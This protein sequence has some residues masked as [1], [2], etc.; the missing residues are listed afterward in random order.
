MEWCN[1]LLVGFTLLTAILI[2]WQI[3]SLIKIEQIKKKIKHTKENNLQNMLKSQ[4]LSSRAI[5]MYYYSYI[6]KDKYAINDWNYN[7]IDESISVIS[8]LAAMNKK[9]EVEKHV[10]NLVK[11]I[12]EDNI[13]ISREDKSR[14]YSRINSELKNKID[15][16]LYSMLILQIECIND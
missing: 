6:N 8:Y 2:G 16:S 14:L 9:E 7:Y 12:K 11:T 4:Y 1:I 3:L 13:Y 15:E 5:S 10:K